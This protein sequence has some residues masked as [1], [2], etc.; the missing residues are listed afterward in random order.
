MYI[1]M[2]ILIKNYCPAI[3]RHIVNSTPIFGCRIHE[4]G[5]ENRILTIL[6]DSPNSSRWLPG[7]RPADSAVTAPARTQL[8][9]LR[10]FSKFPIDGQ[11][12]AYGLSRCRSCETHR[13]RLAGSQ[14][15]VLRTQTL[16]I[17]REHC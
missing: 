17:S 3:S 12:P 8:H 7:L 13:V 6:R 9:S 10:S 1:Q 15:F 16:A 5:D 4:A 11:R 2:K 14:V